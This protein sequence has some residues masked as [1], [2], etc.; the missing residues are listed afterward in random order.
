MAIVAV[1]KNVY[2]VDS[3]YQWDINQVLEIRGLSVPKVPEIHFTNEAM[4]KALVRQASMDDAGVITAEIPNTLL[5]KPYK[6]TAFVCMYEDDTFE[7]LYKITIPV[8]A[9]NMPADYTFQDNDGEIYSFNALE[10]MVADALNELEE[11]YDLANESK[12][13]FEEV[14]KAVD[15]LETAN[16]NL[17]EAKSDY[18]ESKAMYEELSNKIFILK[19]TLVAGE[20]EISFIDDRITE[21]SILSFYSSI[22]GANP[23]VATATPGKLVLTFGVQDVDMEVGVKVNGYFV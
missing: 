12:I 6:I 13:T 17:I 16:E 18:E 20:T 22:F 7:S 8:K 23:K 2:K 9:R 14:T 1:N 19:D 4:E 5:Q 21:N 10:N 15:E 3:L 11:A